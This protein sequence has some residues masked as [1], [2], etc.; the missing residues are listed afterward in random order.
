MISGISIRLKML[1]YKEVIAIRTIICGTVITFL[2]YK[3][4]SIV[5]F[6]Y[7]DLQI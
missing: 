3:H 7:S 6:V 1:N 2:L 4:I 5:I